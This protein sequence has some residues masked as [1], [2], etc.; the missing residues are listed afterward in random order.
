MLRL[1]RR[2]I[3]NRYVHKN[4]PM[5]AG[6]TVWMCDHKTVW[7]HGHK[8]A[9]I[10]ALKTW[11]I[12]ARLIQEL[13]FPHLWALILRALTRETLNQKGRGTH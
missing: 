4:T 7:M 2:N 1:R 5:V 13:Q 6:K 10:P 12:P 9:P 8:T 3:L 11:P